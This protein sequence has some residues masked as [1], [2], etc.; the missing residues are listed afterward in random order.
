M[1]GYPLAR[2]QHLQASVPQPQA[3][4]AACVIAVI[5]CLIAAVAPV[6]DATAQTTNCDACVNASTCEPNRDNCVAECRA[7]LFSIDPRRARCIATC[8]DAVASCTRSVLETC[9]AQHRC[10]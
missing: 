5:A 1:I 8:T 7:Q 4:S 10:P 2:R 3:R 6:C 9:R